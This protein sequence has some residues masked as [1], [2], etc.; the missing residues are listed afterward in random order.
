MKA[1]KI[2]QH[3]PLRVPQ[4]W[5]DQN[6]QLVMQIDRLFDDVYRQLMLIKE[7]IKELESTDS[8]EE[9]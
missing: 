3:E 7:K 2:A 6:A 8:E 9:E 4:G 5:K 1:Q